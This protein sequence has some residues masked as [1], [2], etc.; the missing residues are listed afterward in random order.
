MHAYAAH[1]LLLLCLCAD[2]CVIISEPLR[3]EQKRFMQKEGANSHFPV[4]LAA[5]LPY[6]DGVMKEVRIDHTHKWHK[7]KNENELYAYGICVFYTSM[8]R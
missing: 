4:D 7:N 8:W 1:N 6:L 5:H 3:A 2:F